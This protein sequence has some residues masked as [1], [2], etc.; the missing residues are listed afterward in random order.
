[1]RS[2]PRESLVL[3][4]NPL[5]REPVYLQLANAVRS[6]IAGGHLRPGDQL[7][8]VRSLARR[9]GVNFNTVARAY[10]QLRQGDLLLS[11][12][13][14]GTFVLAPSA[15]RMHREALRTLAAQLVA[16]ARQQRYADGDI[17]ALVERQIRRRQA[18][19]RSGE[20]LG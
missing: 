6:R 19:P 9:L 17:L 12:A 4:L 2:Q 18:T 10:R 15:P 16:Q 1:M 5:S 3:E 14:R 8:T 20:K 11:Q 13:G 7:P